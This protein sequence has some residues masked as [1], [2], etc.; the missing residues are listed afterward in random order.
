MR[1]AGAPVSLGGR[2][3]WPLASASHFP[4]VFL[5]PPMHAPHRTTQI[6]AETCVYAQRHAIASTSRE[7]PRLCRKN[8]GPRQFTVSHH[9]ARPFLQL[10]ATVASDTGAATGVEIGEADKTDGIPNYMLRTSGTVLKLRGDAEDMWFD[11][12]SLVTIMTSDVID[13][14]QQQGNPADLKSVDLGE[15]I[16]IEGLLFDDFKA[17]DTLEMVLPDYNDAVLTLEIV[18]PR[19]L[20]ELDLERL[21]D[22]ASKRQSIASLLSLASGFSGWTARVVVAGPARNGGTVSKLR[23]DLDLDNLKYA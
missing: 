10:Q 6:H 20:S 15:H 23:R 18:E 19:P 22:D 1:A 3:E 13:M 5:P 14:V 12:G 21:S 16:L 11:S 9:C 8:P 2:L 7:P 4:H 17:E